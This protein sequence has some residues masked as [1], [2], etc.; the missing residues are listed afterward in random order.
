[1]ETDYYFSPWQRGGFKILY[2]PLTGLGLDSV[3]LVNVL[4]IG[5]SCLLLIKM[6]DKYLPIIFLSFPLLQGVGG[7][8]Y[9]EIPV[10]L[11]MILAVYMLYRNK[12]FWFALILGFL[13]LIRN[14]TALFWLPAA[15]AMRKDYKYILLMFIFPALYFISAWIFYGNSSQLIE[16]YRVFSGRN[17]AVHPKGEMFH[18]L[19]HLITVGGIWAFFVVPGM[20]R[21]KNRTEMF[22]AICMGMIVLLLSI[23]Y[24]DKTGFG[25][26]SG[27]ARHMLTVAPF[28]A[29]FAWKGLTKY[30]NIIVGIAVLAVFLLP[31][32]TTTAELDLIKDVS[33][34]LQRNISDRDMSTGPEHCAPFTYHPYVNHVLDSPVKRDIENMKSGEILLWESHYTSRYFPLESFAS[35]EDNKL[36]V[37]PG[38][39]LINL[40]QNKMIL[41]AVVMKVIN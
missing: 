17:P 21:N 23:A 13:P 39:K 11:L 7:R 14:E 26:I 27:P 33:A 15:W 32:Y 24:W 19:K 29:Y 5:L 2:A 37:K 3:R 12:L 28:I 4:L 30:K 41:I 18:Y 34:W 20:L 40:V 22:M 36:T 35:I 16:N 10:M 38:W 25:R 31:K 6:G 8:F 9:S 1:M